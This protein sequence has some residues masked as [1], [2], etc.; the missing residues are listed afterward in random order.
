MS[1]RTPFCPVR[2]E[3]LPDLWCQ[4]RQGHEGPHE[5]RLQWEDEAEPPKT[6]D[7]I[8][9]E[10]RMRIYDRDHLIS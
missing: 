4:K 10:A 6:R 5:A 7:E 2:P 3:I 8:M 1:D 9:R